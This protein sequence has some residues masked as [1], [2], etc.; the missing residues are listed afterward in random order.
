MQC[1]QSNRLLRKYEKNKVNE[2][3]V[4]RKLDEDEQKQICHT[5]VFWIV[6]HGIVLSTSKQDYFDI[7]EQ[8][9]GIFKKETLSSYFIPQSSFRKLDDKKNK[10][11]RKQVTARGKLYTRFKYQREKVLKEKSKE[12]KYENALTNSIECLPVNESGSDSEDLILKKWLD[13]N[14]EPWSSIV[15][16]W[17]LTCQLRSLDLKNKTKLFHGLIEEWP[18]YTSR[19]NGFELIN[20]DFDYL[21]PG[22]DN[23]KEM[24]PIF[25]RK[26]LDLA[27][28]EAKKGRKKKQH[29][30]DKLEASF[31]IE[32]GTDDEKNF[33]S[34]LALHAIFYLHPNKNSYSN[35]FL[36]SIIIQA[37]PGDKVQNIIEKLAQEAASSGNFSPKIIYYTNEMNIPYKFYVCVNEVIYETRTAVTAIDVFFKI[38]FVFDLSYPKECINMMT[39][40]QYF[41]YNILY[42][43]DIRSSKL[44]N[45][46]IAIDENI[47]EEFEQR[48]INKVFDQ[49]LKGIS[50]GLYIQSL[51]KL[52]LFTGFEA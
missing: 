10:M 50:L 33:E 39:F 25:R 51:F 45:N 35:Q 21:F 1:S 26:I 11:I 17:K 23:M 32:F 14:F 7:F 44:L 37:K 31:N 18:R 4:H 42:E 41:F 16:N 22:K 12:Q 40:M 47:G 19:Q 36:G 30:I 6:E 13:V 24:W 5:I 28:S 52:F 15:F 38:F 3:I 27:I 9:R 34:I 48:V 49:K 20:I 43:D 2:N 29:I 46:M 8:I